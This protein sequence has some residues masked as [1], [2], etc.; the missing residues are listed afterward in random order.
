MYSKVMMW[1]AIDRGMRLADKRCLP[2]PNYPKWR[3]M[4]DK[5]FEDIQ[6][7]GWK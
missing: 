3:E 6:A 1:V 5:L 7:K 2:C 4:R